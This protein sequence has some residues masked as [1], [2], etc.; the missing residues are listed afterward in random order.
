M[1]QRNSQSMSALRM[2]NGNDECFNQLYEKQ[3]HIVYCFNSPFHISSAHLICY[4]QK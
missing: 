4:L 3:C 1:S 2:A